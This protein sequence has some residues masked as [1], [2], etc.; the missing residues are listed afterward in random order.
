MQMIKKGGY[1]SHNLW[2]VHAH[3][4]VTKLEVGVNKQYLITNRDQYMITDKILQI[5]IKKSF[6]T[7]YR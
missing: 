4:K 7:V 3:K 2:K 6:N 5:Y 1:I